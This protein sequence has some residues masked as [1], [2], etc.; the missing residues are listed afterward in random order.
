[1]LDLRLAAGHGG[2][3][4]LHVLAPLMA[5]ADEIHIVLASHSSAIS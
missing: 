4:V 1:L 2:L 5:I 3:S